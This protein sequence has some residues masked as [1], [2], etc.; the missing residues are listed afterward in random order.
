MSFSTSAGDCSPQQVGK[1]CD[2]R[3]RPGTYI[4]L[5]LTCTFVSSTFVPEKESFLCRA[6]A[7]HSRA[8]LL[9]PVFCLAHALAL[10]E[11]IHYAANTLDSPW[12][13]AFPTNGGCA[14]LEW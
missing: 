13:R 1:V 10:T 6:F 5:P 9:T 14:S 2:I 3:Y 8:L 7:R 11:H 4:E 12:R